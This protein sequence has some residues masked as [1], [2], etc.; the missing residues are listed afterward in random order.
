MSILRQVRIKWR[1]W[2]VLILMLSGLVFLSFTS[3]NQLKTSML[4]TKSEKTSDLVDTAF[5]VLEYYFHKEQAG[6][7]DRQTAQRMAKKAVAA[8][9]YADGNYFWIQD[10]TPTMLM[11]PLKPDLDGKPLGKFTDPNGKPLFIEMVKVV[12][13]S[14]NG[15]VAYQWPKPGMKKPVDKISHV[16]GFEPWGWI[17]GSGIYI[18]DVETAFWNAAHAPVLISGLVMLGLIVL[19][20]LTMHS[21]VKPLEETSSAMYRIATGSGDLSQ[22]LNQDSKGKDELAILSK[23]FNLFIDKLESIVTQIQGTS[24][25]LTEMSSRVR[26]VIE[27]H[28]VT[29]DQQHKESHSIAS[30]ITEMAT[31]AAEIAKI[32]DNAAEATTQANNDA[33][34]GQTIVSETIASV[35]KL[36]AEVSNTSQAIDSLNNDTQNITSVLDVIR[37]I[38]E[39]T[40]LLALNAAIEA[41]RAGEQGRGFSVVADEV[42]TLAARTQTATEE[43]RRMIDL[44]QSTSGKAVQAM[45]SGEQVAKATVVKAEKA[46]TSLHSIVTAIESVTAMNIQIAAAVEEQ[47]VVA[48]EI[49]QSIN[50]IAGFVEKSHSEMTNTADLSREL[51]ELSQSLGDLIGGFKGIGSGR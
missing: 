33:T 41:A 13:K 29:T 17:I 8:L 2:F 35:D 49:D 30:A 50:R 32:T 36:A 51:E 6:E 20:Y 26:A 43:I 11:H 39:Q 28:S 46:G 15:E 34:S 9:R 19:V 45:E 22:R 27:Q 5:S 42:R 14:G 31:A 4:A 3:L 37:S 10:F 21:I 44:L 1:L 38:A 16:K 23:N 25:R 47:S 48:H 40:N 18:D 7:L 12:R 24:S